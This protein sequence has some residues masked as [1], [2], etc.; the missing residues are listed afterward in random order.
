MGWG[1]R[2]GCGAGGQSSRIRVDIS[3]HPPPIVMHLQCTPAQC[4]YVTCRPCHADRAY[5]HAAHATTKCVVLKCKHSPRQAPAPQ[6]T[7]S[8]MISVNPEELVRQGLVAW[9]RGDGGLQGKGEGGW[10]VR[11][12]EGATGSCYWPCWAIPPQ[13]DCFPPPPPPPVI[14]PSPII[15]K[16]G[17]LEMT[18]RMMCVGSSTTQRE[19]RGRAG[20]LA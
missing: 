6:L 2:V 7:M 18:G 1:Q 19:L 10:G 11:L 17:Q 3:S 9:W 8:T 15:Q 5:E 12:R 20:Q 13:C 4:E 14:H 16:M